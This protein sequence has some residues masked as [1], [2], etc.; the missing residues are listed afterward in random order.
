MAR[1]SEYYRVI[2]PALASPG[3]APSFLTPFVLDLN[4]DG[5]DD[6]LALGASFP[7][8][9][10]NAPVAQ[11]GRVLLG[12][13]LGSFK[14]SPAGFFPIST[15]LTIH[16]RKI[17]SADLNDDGHKDLFIASHGWDT[18]PFP[19]EQNRLYLTNPDGS[20]Y[21]ATARLPQLQDFSHSAAAGDID[22][23]GDQ[24]LI[25]GNGYPGQNRIAPY[26]LINDGKGNFTIA[27][28]NLPVASGQAL[29]VL[30]GYQFPGT[31]LQDLNG[32][33]LAD[34]IVTGDRS[35]PQA[36][37]GQ[38]TIFWNDGGRLTSGNITKL[39]DT[40]AFSLHI[41]LDAKAIDINGD[42]LQDLVLIGT[43]GN[44]FYDGSFVQIFRNEGGKAFTDVTASALSPADARGGSP[45]AATQTPWPVWISTLDF[46]G[47]GLTD[48]SLEYL[49]GQIR[50]DTPLI[51]LNDGRGHFNALK[52]SDFV[53]P[54]SEGL[55]GSGLLVKTN[56]GYSFVSFNARPDGLYERGV[57]ATKP[58][59]GMRATQAEAPNLTAKEAAVSATGFFTGKAPDAAAFASRA[60]FAQ[61][62]F[63]YYRDVL[64]VATPGL[65]PYEALGVAFSS[66]S[67]FQ[68]RYGAGSLGSSAFVEK[69][70]ADVFGRPATA[71]QEAAF[72]EQLDYFTRLY[73]DAGIGAAAAANQARG[74]VVGQMTGYVMTSAAERSLAT[75]TLD[76][77]TTVFLAGVGAGGA[78]QY[79]SSWV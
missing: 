64:K 33:G 36:R 8:P 16:P 5:F 31:I 13:G 6:I 28:G 60:E 73:M 46:N 35:S 70:Y 32:D 37:F 52:A 71:A 10:N 34:L 44:P 17:V 26:E 15:L 58:Y 77:K 25:V 75:Q 2:S 38:T 78:D 57:I 59:D 55:L 3:Y 79:G 4:G 72:E 48:F 54:G 66:S 40:T 43:Q 67:D 19:G 56:A 53:A 49:G 42:G 61:S 18:S 69:A 45:G 76:D 50:A 9:S 7:T 65:G 68:T 23:D 62:Q 29:D 51:Y 11:P 22:G 20:F 14:D 63:A 47:D 21:D 41:D 39:P 1:L 74:A 30:T 27:R 24:D 12:D